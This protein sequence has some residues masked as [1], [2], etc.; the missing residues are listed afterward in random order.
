MQ[1][2]TLTDDGETTPMKNPLEE[3]R[4]KPAANPSTKTERN[5]II[6]AIPG[7]IDPICGLWS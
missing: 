1:G 5:K 4:E 3:L 2:G 7:T 6:P